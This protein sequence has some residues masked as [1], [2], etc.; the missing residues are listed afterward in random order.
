MINIQTKI[1]L[2]LTLLFS[3]VLFLA[4]RTYAYQPATEIDQI[5]LNC[6][7]LAPTH[8]D[9]CNDGTWVDGGVNSNGCPKTPFCVK[10]NSTTCPE[11]CTCQDSIIVCPVTG[12]NGTVEETVI[13]ANDPVCQINCVCDGNK[14][15]CKTAVEEPT[16]PEET[17]TCPENCT[18][19]ENRPTICSSSSDVNRTTDELNPDEPKACPIGCICQNDVTVCSSNST[20]ISTILE[21]GESKVKVIITSDSEGQIR[22]TIPESG[23][24]IV[25]NVSIVN[26]QLMGGTSTN[27][28][29]I[30]FPQSWRTLLKSK[31]LQM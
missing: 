28:R 5:P 24:E 7:Q 13:V 23:V 6:P 14:Q 8:P 25:G 26:N 1:V 11:N 19:E 15:V 21:Q 10:N 29:K 20:P 2:A 16:T 30:L 3:F 9:L 4:P 22:M 12:N 31:T 17:P 18:C 27:A